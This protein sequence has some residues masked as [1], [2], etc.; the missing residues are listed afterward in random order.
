MKKELE[1]RK[2]KLIG[3]RIRV[4]CSREVKNEE[5]QLVDVNKVIDGADSHKV[6]IACFYGHCTND[7]LIIVTDGDEVTVTA[8]G[9]H[10]LK[11]E[12]SR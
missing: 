4:C 6:T 1:T 7:A 5:P 12:E 11:I 9:D 3:V 8:L 10:T 2:A